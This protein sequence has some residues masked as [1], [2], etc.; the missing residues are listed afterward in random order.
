MDN[1]ASPL[2]E[3]QRRVEIERD[4]LTTSFIHEQLRKLQEKEPV[5]ERILKSSVTGVVLGSLLTIASNA[6]LESARTRDRSR[7]AAGERARQ[8]VQSFDDLTGLVYEV[9]SAFDTFTDELPGLSSSQRYEQTKTASNALDNAYAKFLRQ[10]PLILSKLRARVEPSQFALI[11]K[12]FDT[13][14]AQDVRSLHARALLAFT[15]AGSREGVSDEAVE[16]MRRQSLETAKCS[17]A[18]IEFGYAVLASP[19]TGTPSEAGIQ[20]ACHSNK[21]V[22]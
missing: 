8:A 9:R 6:Y 15:T 17:D 20:A 21:P 13:F 16:N 1:P 14:V 7:E 18:I 4:R 12:P 11:R 2:D 5:W 22:S 10:A 3:E 19:E